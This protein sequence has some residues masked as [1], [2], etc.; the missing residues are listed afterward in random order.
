[1][2]LILVGVAVCWWTFAVVGL[3]TIANATDISDNK[4]L[5]F[6]I[7]LAVFWPLTALMFVPAIIYQAVVVSTKRIR[8]DLHNRGVLREFEQWLKTR[9]Q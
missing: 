6:A 9:E 8:A 4:S 3:V 5:A 2:E 1:M 7:V